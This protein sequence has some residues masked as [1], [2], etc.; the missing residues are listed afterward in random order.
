LQGILIFNYGIVVYLSDPK[1]SRAREESADSKL[2][3]FVTVV[4]LCLI[5]LCLGLIPIDIYVVSDTSMSEETRNTMFD[6]VQI[7]Y[8]GTFSRDSSIDSIL[9]SISMLIRMSSSLDALS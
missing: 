9:S 4:G 7:L 6:V 3:K 2:P 1:L 8:Y 5:M